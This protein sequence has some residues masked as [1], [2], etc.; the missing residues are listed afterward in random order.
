VTFLRLRMS[1]SR[2]SPCKRRE[3]WSRTEEHRLRVRSRVVRDTG[4]A[5]NIAPRGRVRSPQPLSPRTAQRRRDPCRKPRT[6]AGLI[7]TRPMTAAAHLTRR[8]ASAVTRVRGLTR[9]RYDSARRITRSQQPRVHRAGG[10]YE[11]FDDAYTS[12]FPRGRSAR[13]YTT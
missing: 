11:L 2:T 13:L 8:R 10:C 3:L 4:V 9:V 7:F 12:P 1:S 6:L 5:Y